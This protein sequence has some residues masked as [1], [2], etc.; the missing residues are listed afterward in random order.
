MEQAKT[1]IIDNVEALEA[2]LAAAL[3][4]AHL[5]RADPDDVIDRLAKVRH[6]GD[7][8]LDASPS[9]TKST[10]EG[11][12]ASVAFAAE[13]NSAGTSLFSAPASGALSMTARPPSS[14]TLMKLERPMK[15]K[16]NWFFG[17]A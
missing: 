1:A 9:A 4:H 17:F 10:S 7:D 6:T 13:A 15:L 3:L 16:T 2:R 12:Q 8:A 5:L 14:F 11:R